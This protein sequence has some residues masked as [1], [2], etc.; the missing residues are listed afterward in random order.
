MSKEDKEKLIEK[1]RLSVVYQIRLYLTTFRDEK[2]LFFALNL[3]GD[4]ERKI[5]NFI[6]DLYR[7][8]LPDLE[9][10]LDFIKFH[11]RNNNGQI[12]G[13]LLTNIFFTII[14]VLEMILYKF[15]L[16][17]TGL[18]EDMRNDKEVVSCLKE[19]EIES[20]ASRIQFS[21]KV[22]LILKLCMKSVQKF[23]ENKIM[24]FNKDKASKI[25]TKGIGNELSSKPP[26]EEL[27]EKYSDL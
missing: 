27:K 19:I 1:E 15:G 25:N 7:K 2:Q 21:P 22:D 17:V 12:T 8:R 18:A 23:S 20:V 3:D 11:V 9:K 5:N 6:R 10:L 24:T 16:D 14:K 26:N 13:N 4:D